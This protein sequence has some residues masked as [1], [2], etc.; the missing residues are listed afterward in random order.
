[1]TDDDTIS[2]LIK[3]LHN[4]IST[5]VEQA[6][7][8]A[9]Q[10]AEGAEVGDEP[11]LIP[12]DGLI[13]ILKHYVIDERTLSSIQLSGVPYVTLASGWQRAAELAQQRYDGEW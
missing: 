9:Q 1:M 5:H 6:H 2:R 10:A 4:Y 13:Q 12:D 3:E 11:V 7:L 8:R